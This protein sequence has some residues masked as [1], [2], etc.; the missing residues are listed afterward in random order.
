MKA[1]YDTVLAG[2]DEPVPVGQRPAISR[3]WAT[4]DPGEKVR[5]YAAFVTDLNMRVGG[6]AA[7][8]AEADPEVAQVRA[9]TEAERLAGLRAFTAHLA[10]EGLLAP[11]E[12]ERAADGCWVLTSLPVFVQ[13]TVARGWG[14][15]E[16]RDWLTL[17]L[18]A[19]LLPPAGGR[20]ADRR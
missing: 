6:L 5:G 16:Y 10:E 18:A 3:I 11:A 17:M 4:A 9:V 7:V 2:D 1:V 15:E 20:G 14:A 8:L 19:A 12:T 13:L